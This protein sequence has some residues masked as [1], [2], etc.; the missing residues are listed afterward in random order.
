MVNVEL[1][2]SATSQVDLNGL[3]RTLFGRPS[4][5]ISLQDGYGKYKDIPVI[6][7]VVGGGGGGGNDKGRGGGGGGARTQELSL[8][9]GTTYAITIGAGG[10]GNGGFSPADGTSGNTTNFEFLGPIL[11]L[12]S[13]WATGGA[14]GRGMG[15]LNDYGA[16]GGSSGS[17]GGYA[18]GAGRSDIGAGGGGGGAGGSGNSINGGPGAASNVAPEIN[19]IGVLG[20]G[21]GGGGGTTSGA[22]T[23]GSYGGG[24]GGSAYQNGQPGIVN[25]GGGGGGGGWTHPTYG[26]NGGSG[27]VVMRIPANYSDQFTLN[28]SGQYTQTTVT[29]T[30]LLPTSAPADRKITGLYR[31]FTFT[32]SGNLSFS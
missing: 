6:I 1:G 29:P 17:P 24:N 4:G 2:R 20:Y 16:L 21:A 31:I 11:P 3:P 25:T 10:A 27:C 22:S 8:T 13:Y 12:P 28:Y 26:G 18:G 9:R 32:T 19:N 7:Y 5:Q 30:L 14:G 15:R 23:G